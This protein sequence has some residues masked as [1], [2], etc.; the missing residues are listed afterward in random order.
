MECGLYT[1][2]AHVQTAEV[3]GGDWDMY[4]ERMNASE[5]AGMNRHIGVSDSLV[6]VSK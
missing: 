3:V 2:G 1:A 4:V 5:L 6:V